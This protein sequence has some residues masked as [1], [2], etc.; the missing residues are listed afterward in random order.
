[1]LQDDD[2]ESNFKTYKL[3]YNVGG[4]HPLVRG[5][6]KKSETNGVLGPNCKEKHFIQGD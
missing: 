5:P 6:G 2:F 4:L 3:E 1:M